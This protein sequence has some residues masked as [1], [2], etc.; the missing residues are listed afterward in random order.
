MYYNEIDLLAVRRRCHVMFLAG[1]GHA[2]A[3]HSRDIPFGIEKRRQ[4][5]QLLG[6][7]EASI[8]VC[9]DSVRQ[10]HFCQA[11]NEHMFNIS[12]M[13]EKTLT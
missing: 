1:G 11:N 5:V 8:A 7:W 10:L 12:H 2:A 3:D 9:C 6:G 13:S 4:R